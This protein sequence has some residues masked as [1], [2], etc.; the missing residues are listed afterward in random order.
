MLVFSPESGYGDV[1]PALDL[2][3]EGEPDGEAGSVV[4]TPDDAAR[5]QE[6]D[7]ES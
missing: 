5:Q 7:D 6:A 2:D 1:L 3:T 4:D